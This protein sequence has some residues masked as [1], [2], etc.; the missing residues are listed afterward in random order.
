[1]AASKETIELAKSYL[2][3]IKSEFE[4][5]SATEHTYRAALK[6]FMEALGNGIT[7]INEPKRVSCGA[8]D[9]VV[10][11]S[12]LIIGHIEAKDIG[13]S[14]D[15]AERSEQLNRYYKSLD[16]LVLTDYLEFRWYMKGLP[17]ETARL[18]KF[19]K[20]E[21][22][23]LDKNGMKSV[24]SLLENFLTQ[25][26][27]PIASSGELSQRLAYLAHSIRDVIIEA[28]DTENATN[29]LWNLRKAFASV[30]IPDMDQ[31]QKTAEFAD[32]YAQTI[33]Y[34]LFAARCN[35]KG[36]ETFQR[37]GAAREI[38]K[39]NPFLR[40][41][42]ETI[43][44]T[45]LDEEPYVN[46]V[47]YVVQILANTD[48][49]K[50]L[51]DFGKKT[52]QEDPIVHFYEGFLA[53]YDPALRERRGVYY[54]PEPP[55]SFIV[56]S[57]DYILK[58]Y[59]D[60]GGGLADSST[61]E[62][63]RETFFTDFRGEPEK[64]ALPTRIVH[65]T[66][67]KVLV[68]DPATGTGTFLYAIVNLIRNEFMKYGNAGMWSE[69]VKRY[70]L[71][72]IFGFEL[73]MAPYTI[74]HFKLG[75]QLAGQDLP[76]ELQKDWAYDFKTDE[77]F[78][79]KSDERLG[80]Y[81][82]NTLEESENPWTSL[83][84]YEVIGKEAR[85]ASVVKRDYPIMIVL[86]NPPY[87]ANSANNGKWIIDLVRRDYY[88]RDE[89][90]EQNPKLLLDDYVKFI[91]WGQW[92]I[93]HTGAGVLAFI[94]NHGYLDNPTFR[95]MRKSLMANFTK[96]YILNLH[97]NSKKKERSPDGS[98]DENI[99]DIQQG[100][101]IG[102][103]IKEPNKDGP[104]IV[105]HAD[106]W[107]SRENKYDR[108]LETDISNTNWNTIEP[109]HPFYLFKP[110]DTTLLPEYEI[111]W[112][113]V[114]IMPL[115]SSGVRTHRDNFAFDPDPSELKRRIDDFRNLS[116]SDEEIKERY[117]LHDT[118][119]WK[120]TKKRLISAKDPNWDKYFTQCLYRPF[121]LRPYYHS[122]NIVEFPKLEVMHNMLA[123]DNKG[124]LWIRPMSPNYEFSI[125]STKYIIDQCAIGNKSAGAGVSY[126]GVLYKYPID[127]LLKDKQQV[128]DGASWTPGKDG[129]I[130][131]L[132]HDFISSFESRLSLR[133]ISEGNGDLKTT[134]GPEDVFDYIYA[135]LHSPT[136]RKR[137]AEFL[138]MDFPRVP[139][140]SNVEL[141][142]GLC[143]LGKK[144]VDLHLLESQEVSRFLT[145]YPIP[146]NNHVEKGFPKYTLVEN[147]EVGKVFINK[148]Q[149]FEGVPKEVWNFYVGGYQVCEK[150]IKDRR[151]RQLSYD[152]LTHYQKVIV[153]LKETI[154]LMKEIDEAIPE[155]PI[156]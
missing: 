80:I 117:N 7:A 14:L 20:D 141:F 16:N 136:Y 90:K 47:D 18:A 99:F 26:V 25:P 50:V 10:K 79:I 8:P 36:S 70:V 71:T 88:P 19:T 43:T 61:I 11:K 150:W 109:R 112:K 115:N 72:R 97:G 32:M 132:N 122:E 64:N 44:G 126:L 81:L 17:R 68:L 54:T 129:R 78:S 40:Q 139:L 89:M 148:T 152:D 74:A 147:H 46:Y 95:E 45:S 149:Y 153:A 118:R 113:I 135:I 1:M 85:S 110:Q 84:G 34:G 108:L 86:G 3:S 155:W 145:R 62:F 94:T 91:R 12:D 111:N 48:I 59:F 121:D 125:L 39:T 30:L 24:V 119:D 127:D 93:A 33:V 104:A 140:T 55:V 92:R 37:L 102:I 87:S 123:K 22:I 83:W 15:E 138:K 52:K 65:E 133:F 143:T 76:P 96:I 35:H 156:T 41:L 134:F 100:V 105:Y 51:A 69:Y 144:M 142:R 154:R 124:L 107:G 151:G 116:I 101:A 49:E 58:K 146:G 4:T 130:P 42:F 106:L 137:Y 131:N 6:S 53:A 29:Q 103:F 67:P 66:R 60:L 73:L 120:L 21:K 9:F 56:R 23:V 114:D 98:K 38:P 28:F 57:V 63:D 5:R 82:T 2:A 31:P 77:R 75:M 27:E 128:L 13:K